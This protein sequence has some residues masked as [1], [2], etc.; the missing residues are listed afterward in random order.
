M[1]LCRKLLLTRGAGGND[2]VVALNATNGQLIWQSARLSAETFVNVGAPP[3]VYQDSIIMGS[4]GG[5]VPPGGPGKGTVTAL[6]R[7][8]GLHPHL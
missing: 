5:D 3:V 6:N 1:Y 2:T 4:A 7:T 8:T